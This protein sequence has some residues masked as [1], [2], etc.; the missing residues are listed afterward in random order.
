MPHFPGHPKSLH[1]PWNPNPGRLQSLLG[2]GQGQ[3][4]FG[5]NIRQG[6]IGLSPGRT[7]LL[8]HPLVWLLRELWVV[9]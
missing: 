3:G 9:P 2:R 7:P 4:L 8:Q 5:P 1:E 6:G